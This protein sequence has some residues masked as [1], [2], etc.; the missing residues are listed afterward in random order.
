MSILNPLSWFTSYNEYHISIPNA[1]GMNHWNYCNGLNNF[2]NSWLINNNQPHLNG[3]TCGTYTIDGIDY[4]TGALNVNIF[5]PENIKI[6]KDSYFTYEKRLVG[7]E[8]SSNSTSVGGAVIGVAVLPG[9]AGVNQNFSNNS[10]RYVYEPYINI[11]N[12]QSKEKLHDQDQI[13]FILNNY[14]Q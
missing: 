13:P 10:T 12:G 1:D 4:D 7:S 14:F 5:I 6:S 2:L 3:N 11:I 9:I 8:S